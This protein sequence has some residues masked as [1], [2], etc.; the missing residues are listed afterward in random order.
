MDGSSAQEKLDLRTEITA[1]L[2]RIHRFY[3]D[4]DLQNI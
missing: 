4:S 1:F 3:S 2:L